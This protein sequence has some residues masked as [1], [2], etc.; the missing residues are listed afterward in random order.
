[1]RIVVLGGAGYQATVTVKDLVSSGVEEVVIADRNMERAEKL[2][3]ELSTE[4][5]RVLAVS[6]DADNSKSLVSAMEG[7]NAIASGIGPFYKYGAHIVKAAIEARVNFAD[8]NDD[9]DSTKDCL[10]LND[11]AKRAGVTVIVGMGVSPGM[12]NILARYGADRLDSVDEINLFWTA[13][14]TEP[15]GIAV[16]LHTLHAATGKIPTFRGGKETSIDASSEKEIVEFLEP[17]GKQEVHQCG[18]PEPITIPKYI[19]GVRNIN[20]KGGIFPA[21][22]DKFYDLLVYFGFSSKKPVK[23]SNTVMVPA[24]VT[25]ELIHYSEVFK[26]TEMRGPKEGFGTVVEVIGE[27]NSHSVRY[28]YMWNGRMHYLTGM[29]L[30]I[31][32]QMLAR[33]EIIKPGVFAP[34]GCVNSAKFLSEWKKRG[35]NIIEIAQTRREL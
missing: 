27:K 9:Y 30:S 26:K 32:T 11:A 28:K 3:G 17:I 14:A 25:N 24:E 12:T 33:G 20:L 19:E 15:S 7:A 13:S 34:E 31:V 8:M 21:S 16:G 23:I 29:S 6:I 22:L 2:A 10:G 18:H 5:T 4:R 35:L 1:M